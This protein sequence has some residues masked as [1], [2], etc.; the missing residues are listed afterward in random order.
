VGRLI[1]LLR[2]CAARANGAL[3]PN[4]SHGEIAVHRPPPTVILMVVA[5]YLC[6]VFLSQW[7]AASRLNE[8]PAAAAAS[9]TP[10][11]TLGDTLPSDP[12]GGQT[13]K[14]PQR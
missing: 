4:D 1:T 13:A 14:S 10:A 9:I 3:A 2:N 6:V 11:S 7:I 5:I 8:A 12:G